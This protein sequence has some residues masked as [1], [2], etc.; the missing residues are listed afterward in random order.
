MM[1]DV[2]DLEL[3]QIDKILEKI[4]NDPEA[5]IIRRTETELWEKIREKAIQGRRTG[6][7][8]TAEGD[9]LAA[10]GLSTVRMRPL[11]FQ[12]STSNASYKCLSLL[13]S[14]SRGKR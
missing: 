12:E 3:E 1:D 14:F 9:M 5:H 4:N 2:I 7:G 6:I 11:I 13:R 10:L 8:I